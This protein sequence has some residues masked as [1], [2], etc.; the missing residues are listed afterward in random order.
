MNKSVDDCIQS[1]DPC[2]SVVIVE[3]SKKVLGYGV[4][5]P[6]E[7]L[8]KCGDYVKRLLRVWKIV[9]DVGKGDSNFL[10]Q[11]VESNDMLQ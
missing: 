11:S 8:D 6:A 7:L 9:L 2:V 4:F 3:E 10:V 5:L 1:R